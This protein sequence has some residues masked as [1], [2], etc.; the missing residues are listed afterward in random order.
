MVLPAL[1]GKLTARTFRVNLLPDVSVVDLTVELDKAASYEEI[2]AE[3]KAQ[4][5]KAQ[6]KAFGH[7]EDN[8]GDWTSAA[9][10]APVLFDVEGH[11]TDG[12][13]SNW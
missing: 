7:T 10:P 2:C 13:P 9:T 3:M 12:T 1:K 6:P 11:C 4:A 8:G 5:L